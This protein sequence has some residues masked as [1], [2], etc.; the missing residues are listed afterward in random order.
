DHLTAQAGICIPWRNIR[1]GE[2]VRAEGVLVGA[3]VGCLYLGIVMVERPDSG[4]ALLMILPGQSV[5]VGD[6]G[7]AQLHGLPCQAQCFRVI[8]PRPAIMEG[9]FS[10]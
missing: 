9:I 5:E 3:M 1:R 8:A 10:G 2:E 4:D 6:E 7:M